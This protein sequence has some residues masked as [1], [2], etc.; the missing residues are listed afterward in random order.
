MSGFLIIIILSIVEGITE[1]LPISSTGH[2]IIVNS[3]L[4]TNKYISKGFMDTF[5]IV[6]QFGAILAVIIYFWDNISPFKKNSVK[7][8]KTFN[9]YIKII[10]GLIPAIILGF[11]LDDYISKFFLNNVYIV[12][13]SLIFYGILLIIIEIYNLQDNEKKISSINDIPYSI[14]F[15]IGLFQCL[16]M[17][18]GTSRSGATIIGALLLGVS[19]SAATEYSFYLAIPTM[20]GATMLKLLKSNLSFTFIEILYLLFGVIISFIVAL[21]SIKFLMKFLK[22]KNFIS[23]GMY[24]IILGII[25]FIYFI[26]IN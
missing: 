2:M 5:L 19:R 7:L 17:I 26:S 21:I 14:V 15:F 18:P 16:A 25:V 10:F 4:N 12:A 6:V 24:R 11:L 9:I 3:L 8:I 20:L 1:F 22:R 23:F 13:S